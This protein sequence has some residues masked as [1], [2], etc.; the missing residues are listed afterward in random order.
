MNNKTDSSVY[1]DFAAL[2]SWQSQM[3]QINGSAM[4]TLDSFISTVKDLKNSW[5]GNS[6]ESFL[7]S[8][9]N[10]INKAKSYHTEMRNVENFLTN[11]IETMDGQ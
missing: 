7:T 4:D 5:C 10:L 1:V 3:D 8:S 6:A 2:N 11:V 9:N